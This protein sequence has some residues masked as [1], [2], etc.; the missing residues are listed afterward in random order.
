MNITAES[1]G[2]AIMFNLQGE[3]TGDS[4]AAFMQAVEHQLK[5]GEVIDIVLNMEMVN[6][7]D[8]EALECLLDLQDRLAE[9]FGQ[10]K[11]VKIDESVRT[12]LEITRLANTFDTYD[13]VNNAVKAME[14]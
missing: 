13:D 12:I 11:L 10:I 1:Y 9:R 6:F 4:L 7:I 8:S 2:H 5:D 3:L 14:A